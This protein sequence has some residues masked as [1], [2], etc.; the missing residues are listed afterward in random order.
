MGT[1]HWGLDNA[2]VLGGAALDR[3]EA[4]LY[5]SSSTNKVVGNDGALRFDNRSKWEIARC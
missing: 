5:L 3:Q 2:V 1:K 4:Y